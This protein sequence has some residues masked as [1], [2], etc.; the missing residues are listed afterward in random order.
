MLLRI[1]KEELL[2]VDDS[3]NKLNYNEIIYKYLAILGDSWPHEKV[4][5][6]K[7]YKD[8]IVW[9]N[10]DWRYKMTKLGAKDRNN[11]ISSLK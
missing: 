9:G 5:L 6:G 2:E 7:Q 3:L 11:I 4:L 8:I 10:A 1:D